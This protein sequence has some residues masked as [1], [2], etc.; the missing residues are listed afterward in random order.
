[1]RGHVGVHGGLSHWDRHLELSS[2][3]V[4]QDSYYH[5]LGSLI[6]PLDLLINYYSVQELQVVSGVYSICWRPCVALTL[7]VGYDA[8][9]SGTVYQVAPGWW[10][11]EPCAHRLR[12]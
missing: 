9:G 8:V 11:W 12:P 5:A 6:D 1:M 4:I 3:Y 2:V 7:E 10:A